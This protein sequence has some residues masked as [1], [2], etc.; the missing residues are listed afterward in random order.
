MAGL[1]PQEMEG[2]A[3]IRLLL[4]AVYVGICAVQDLKRRKISLP[5]TVC[6]G[7]A[8]FLLDIPIM[9]KGGENIFRLIPGMLPGAMFLLLS[10]AAE[11]AAGKGDGYCFLVLADFAPFGF[12]VRNPADDLQESGEKNQT[13][14]F[15]FHRPC[16]SRRYA[17]VP[18]ENSMVTGPG[19]GV[20][21]ILC[22][23]VKGKSG[24]SAIRSINGIRVHVQ[25]GV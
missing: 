11:G 9:A 7:C 19:K 16:L 2:S 22:P 24:I 8:A 23:D 18:R 25:S 6:A 20:R 12:S 3:G 21:P 17:F 10:L 14:F 1:F 15:V 5:V 4:A 13:A